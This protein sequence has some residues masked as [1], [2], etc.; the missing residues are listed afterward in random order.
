[1]K[2]N[3]LPIVPGNRAA[4]GI[5][6]VASILVTTFTLVLTPPTFAQSDP[7]STVPPGAGDAVPA[8]VA[9]P[10]ADAPIDGVA[11]LTVV[12]GG[13]ASDDSSAEHS[14]WVR[15]G[16]VATDNGNPQD[17]VLE[18]PQVVDPA[19]TQ[20]SDGAD[21]AAR[22]GASS[23]DDQVGSIND[24]QDEEDIG[25]AGVYINQIPQGGPNPY[26]ISSY[27]INPRL[28]PGFAPGYVPANPP[29]SNIALL[30]RNGMNTAV[31]STSPM[32]PTT[33]NM[34]PGPGG[35]WWTRAR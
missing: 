31:G 22:D 24:Y 5:A 6:A 16:D 17:Q 32:L 25:V 19:D 7:D 21:Q 14:G 11:P 34:A 12:A 35:G 28:N 1:M 9:D 26:G 30:G 3:W 20:P 18:V 2:N 13:S 15:S 29:R 23:S 10:P 4:V 8:A 27:R 33:H